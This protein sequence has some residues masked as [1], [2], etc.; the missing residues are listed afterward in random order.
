MDNGPVTASP[1][2]DHAAPDA[3]AGGHGVAPEGVDPVILVSLI[4]ESLQTHEGE[5]LER[6]ATALDE[7][8][9]A[10]GLRMT[11]DQDR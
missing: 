10:V 2:D 7:L 6:L 1:S 9:E 4:A 5:A 8:T 11:V 3:D